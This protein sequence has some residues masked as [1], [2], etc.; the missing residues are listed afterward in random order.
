MHHGFSEFVIMSSK[1]FGAEDEWKPRIDNED[2]WHDPLDSQFI[3][4]KKA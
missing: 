1:R 2:G 4:Y 3:A